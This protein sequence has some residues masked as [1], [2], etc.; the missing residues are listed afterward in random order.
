[1]VAT[2]RLLSIFFSASARRFP[3]PS[4]SVLPVGDSSYL[5][6][7]FIDQGSSTRVFVA[8][9]IDSANEVAPGVEYFPPTVG[10][11]KAPDVQ[12]PTQVAVKCLSTNDGRLL[13]LMQNEFQVY[14]K[15][16]LVESV[17]KPLGYYI[18]PQ[19]ECGNDENPF[20]CQYLVMSRASRDMDRL[21]SRNFF[22]LK[23]PILRGVEEI[24]D[25]D[26]L[27]SFELFLATYGLALLAEL[28]KLHASGIVHADI[29]T[30]NIAIDPKDHRSPFLLD[31]GLSKFLD[32]YPDET[33]RAELQERDRSRV[34]YVLISLIENRCKR[35][36]GDGQLARQNDLY[37][38]LKT[39]QDT[40]T[41]T[42]EVLESFLVNTSFIFK[43]KIIYNC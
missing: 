5:I 34:A 20:T 16:N 38:A 12:I 23:P 33:Q 29:R 35:I 1:M 28:R 2:F 22:K 30:C 39:S 8:Q 32:D 15:L 43:G 6:M 10:G 31:V 11:M 26:G 37:S 18:S 41:G 19:W 25:T 36:Y 9:R 17:R 7:K 3:S 21:V 27:Y 4:R 42:Q 13:R 24:S 40:S 14:L